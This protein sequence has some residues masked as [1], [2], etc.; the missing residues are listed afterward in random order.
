MWNE[1]GEK[2]MDGKR[3]KPSAGRRCLALL[4]TASLLCTAC[5]V[6]GRTTATTMR[7][8]HTEG[9]V[10]ISDSKG[11]EVEV[12]EELGLYG[13]YEVDTLSESYAWINLDKVKLTKMDQE[14][15]I[16][17]QKSGKH[18]EIVVNEGSLYFHVTEPL[19][20]D[21]T[22][23]IRTSSMIVGIRGTC[24]WVEVPEDGDT[25]NV[26]LLEGKVRCETETGPETEIESKVETKAEEEDDSSVSQMVKDAVKDA[27]LEKLQGGKDGQEE[28]ADADKEDEDDRHKTIHAGEMAAVSRDGRITVSQF[29]VQDIPPFILEEIAEDKELLEKIGG[30]SGLDVSNLPEIMEAL[31]GLEKGENPSEGSGVQ[32]PPE[33][34]EALEQYRGIIRQAA[35]AGSQ[36]A[37]VQMT[38]TSAV[39]TLLLA[40]AGGDG[41]SDVHA[42][43][44]E[45]GIMHQPAE[46]VRIGQSQTEGLRA[47]LSMAEDGNGLFLLELYNVADHIHVGRVTLNGDSLYTE[48]LYL[49]YDTAEMDSGSRY[50]AVEWHNT[51][52]TDGLDRWRADY[53][54]AQCGS[55][56]ALPE[57]TM[58]AET[59]ETLLS[60]TTAEQAG[61]TLPLEP[62]I[63]ETTI[64]EAAMEET[65]ATEYETQRG[66][67]PYT[68]NETA[69]LTDGNRIV[70]SG[71]IGT[72]SHDEVVALQGAPDPNG[73]TGGTYRLIILD[74]P[75]SMT[76]KSGDGLG[77]YTGTVTMID[78]SYVSGL[79]AYEGQHR[80]FSIDP[81]RAHWP[82]DTSIPLGQPSTSDV[83]VLD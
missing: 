5:Q 21:E 70:F 31:S 41:M 80:T 15:A 7:L 30:A 16:E 75:Q 42:F 71:T 22:L 48:H 26:F 18:L 11:K 69:V 2:I 4:L 55:R 78:V 52:D 6:P 45:N 63:P 33:V 19:A 65:A 35:S 17:I 43:H 8:T 60:E 66:N 34:K 79:D 46:T 40:Q 37:L 67:L 83:H 44:Y 9:Q 20:D 39:P 14:S 28:E 74:S 10:N 47:K 81:N 25:A 53:I 82:S 36:Y 62:T 59:E 27:L 51:Q 13:G 29:T 12:K 24:G 3:K 49:D 23:N 38:R 32:N 50:K 72:Y 58:A 57:E 56:S 77:S 68:T 54:P 73:N 64:P 76:L 1:K 61:E